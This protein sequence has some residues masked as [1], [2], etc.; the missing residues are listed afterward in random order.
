[1]RDDLRLSLK[2]TFT[3]ARTSIDLWM[4][5]ATDS[6]LIAHLQKQAEKGVHVAIHYDKNGG[7]SHLPAP[8]HAHPIRCKGLMHRK[9]TI[10]DSSTVFIGSANLT[11]S[12]LDHH[13]NLSL[14]IY[15]PKL[16]HFLLHP[17][18]KT[19][20]F[21]HG[22]LWLLPDLGAIQ[23]IAQKIN[24]ATRSIFVAMFTLT[25]DNLLDALIRAHHRGVHVFVAIDHYTARGAS[26]KAIQKLRAAQIPVSQSVGLHLLHHKWALIDDTSLILGSTNWT[27]AAFSKNDDI[28]VFLELPPHL[29]TKMKKLTTAIRKESDLL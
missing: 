21:R 9:I 6:P 14:G 17:T 20:T 5:A 18:A 13:D 24:A 7:T 26:K 19:Y 2:K 23:A 16:A 10:V 15:D 29:Q 4:Y 8:I 22:H 1:M 3:N 12:S 25:Q 28:L 27:A 11:T